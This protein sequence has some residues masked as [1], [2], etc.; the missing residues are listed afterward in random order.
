[1]DNATFD[2][3]RD[4]NEQAV[5]K[6]IGLPSVKAA[7]RPEA[8]GEFT[9]LMK[10][11]LKDVPFTA[12]GYLG[13]ITAR[14]NNPAYAGFRATNPTPPPPTAPQWNPTYGGMGMGSNPPQADP[15]A[16]PPTP[17]SAEAIAQQWRAQQA[18]GHQQMAERMARQQAEHAAHHVAAHGGPPPDY[19][20]VHKEFMARKQAYDSL[21]MGWTVKKASK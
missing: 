13:A 4:L 15:N 14:L 21:G 8:L 3:T 18:Q 12:D 1:M 20:N 5:E 7:I 11:E 16:P 19:S 9:T 2:P 10:R 17:G 6:A